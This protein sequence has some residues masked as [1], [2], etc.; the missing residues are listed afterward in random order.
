MHRRTQTALVT[1]GHSAIDRSLSVKLDADAPDGFVV[2]SFAGDDPLACRDHVRTKAGL[3]P[4]K[5]NGSGRHSA[6]NDAIE[7]ALMTAVAAQRRDGNKRRIVA[8]Y[9]YTD[10]AGVLI[11]QVLRLEPKGFRQRRP[12]GKGGWIWE[13]DERRVLYHW[14]ELLKYPNG[15]V[16]ICEGEKDA[17]RITALGHC[18]TT[19][20][21]GKW[22]EECVTALAGRDVI[23]LED[24]DDAGR[25]KALAA[26]QALRRTAKTI[27]I[28][29]L[30]DLPDKGDVSDWLD[31]DPRRAEK[32][33]DVCF[34][35]RVWTP[36][37]VSANA[38]AEAAATDTRAETSAES[39]P[40]EPPPLPFIN[41][42]AWDGVTAPEREWVVQVSRAAKKRHPF[43]RR[44][45][46][47]EIHR[48]I[49]PRRGDAN[50]ARLAQRPANAG[51]SSRCVL[52]GRRR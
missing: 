25:A 4:F 13:L 7:R 47:R 52:R 2:H 24:N 41:I 51:P 32:L 33:V 38:A 28:V 14:P 5:P 40:A 39:A 42:A 6:S 26:A 36:D 48:L 23:I 46:R 22:T 37:D 17:D 8:K 50:R 19:V 21:A 18:A 31:A 12:D 1:H 34:D 29:S 15:T 16:F 35:M 11:Y 45:R 20:A 30:P 10:A 9:D 49:A 3:K 27:R 44:R 43:E